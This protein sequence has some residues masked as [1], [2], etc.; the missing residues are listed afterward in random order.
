MIWLMWSIFLFWYILIRSILYSVTT[1]ILVFMSVYRDIFFSILLA[2]IVCDLLWFRTQICDPFLYIFLWRRSK[3]YILIYISYRTCLYWH[4]SWCCNN[5]L[6][7]DAILY[8]INMLFLS[9]F[10]PESYHWVVFSEGLRIAFLWFLVE[11]SV[12]FLV[13]I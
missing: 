2:K 5:V 1:S 4:I 3:L 13:R 9:W 12:R 8:V 10:F 6:M 7:I 11:F